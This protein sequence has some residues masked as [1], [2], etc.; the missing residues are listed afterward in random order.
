MA[1]ARRAGA[2]VSLA[3]FDV[4]L[5][6]AI[7]FD[8]PRGRP[9]VLRCSKGE[10]GFAKLG[11]CIHSA[12]ARAGLQRDRSIGLTPH[13][14][15]IYDTRINDGAMIAEAR[16]DAPI[17]WRVREFVLVQSLV[18]RGRHIHLGRWTLDG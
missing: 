18:G 12:M 4:T 1:A 5:D 2:A 10:F 6:R 11:K 16:L 14:T 17:T 9:L 7:S 3:P 8:N 13:V 15:L